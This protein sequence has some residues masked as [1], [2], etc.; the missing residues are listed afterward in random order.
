VRA[1]AWFI[2]AAGTLALILAAIGL[3]GV[4]AFSVSRRIR[5]IGIRKAL[6][7]ETSAVVAM[8]VR[9]GMILVG[10]GGLIGAALAIAGAR[11]LSSVLFVGTFDMLS[12]AAG[13]GAL[14][15]VAALAHLIPAWRA[16]RVDPMISLRGG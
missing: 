14:A 8:V 15:V 11:V 9:R 2:G 7:A 1:G 13:F 10:L 5:E 12:F 6:G 3:Y 4:I 16:S